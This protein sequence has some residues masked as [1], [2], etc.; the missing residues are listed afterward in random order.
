M[1]FRE[2]KLHNFYLSI[3]YYEKKNS[4]QVGQIPGLKAEESMQ[5]PFYIFVTEYASIL[6]SV[7]INIKKHP[8]VFFF[9]LQYLG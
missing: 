3:Y 6:L 1:K 4:G 7:F 8:T 9:F 5:V 2:S